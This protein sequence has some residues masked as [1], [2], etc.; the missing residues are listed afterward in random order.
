MT[1]ELFQQASDVFNDAQVQYHQW[2]GQM[3]NLSVGSITVL[4]ALRSNLIP[5][6]PR[7]LWLLQICWV[8][9]ATSIVIASVILHSR[10]EMLYQV[11][12]ELSKMA[13]GAKPLEPIGVPPNV[14]C[15][16]SMRALPYTLAIAICTLTAF[17]VLNTSK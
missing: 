8:S 14:L 15:K 12:V 10:Q 13:T 6:S 17:A 4:I 1:R 16:L 9:L 11:G 2:V 5:D 3:M 7:Y